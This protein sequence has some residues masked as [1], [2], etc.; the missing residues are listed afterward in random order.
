M[1]LTYRFLFFILLIV[2]STNCARTGSPD[3]GPKDEDAPLL[4]TSNPPYETTNFKKK[5]IKLSFDEYIKLKDLQK[6]LVVSPPLKT[7]LIISPQG[8]STKYLK[9]KIVDTLA[10]N[11][12][13][14]FNFGNAIEDNNESNTLEGFKYVF[15]TGSYIDSLKASGSVK[16][17][18]SAELPKNINVVLYRID[19]TFTDSIIFKKKPNYITNTQDTT[20]FNFSNMKKGKYLLAALKETSNDYI[21]D[22]KNDEIGFYTDTLYLPKD[23][24]VK[25]NIALFKEIQPYKFKRGNEASKGKIL[26]GYEGEQTDLKVRVLSDVPKDFK[27]ISK[28]EKDKDTLNY[29]HTPIDAD[30]LNFVVSNT[31]FLDTVTVR[32]RKKKIDSLKVSSS[33]SGTFHLRDTL[34]LKAN[35]PIVKIDTSKISII[36]KDTLA[37]SFSSYI[38]S[39]VNAVAILFDKKQKEN[40]TINILPEALSDIYDFKND[41]LKY[42]FRTMELEDYGKLTLK[43][44]NPESK[45][46]IIEL[47]EGKN[48]DKLVEK[49]F[50]TNSETLVFDLLEPKT[51]FVR[52]IIDDNKNNKWDT[53]NYLQKLQ[54]EKIIYYSEELKVRANYYIENTFTVS[55]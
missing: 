31:H 35:N 17:A 4:V 42:S 15:S 50:I 53:G 34:Y 29:W 44:N 13:Y 41:S 3:G 37:V 14:I 21:F 39:K 19:S 10:K 45:N 18:K 49:R 36:D 30:S 9:L 24:I 47:L 48:K 54:P 6:Q 5:E 8:T 26:F 23:S 38:S 2:C 43:V 20:I 16:N 46:L 7:P 28:F 33:I 51:Y 1:K 22:P 55:E 25:E 11:T 12:T 27:S 40:Y 52:A 32:L